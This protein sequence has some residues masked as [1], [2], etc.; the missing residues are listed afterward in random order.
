VGASN[1][2]LT[3]LFALGAILT[4]AGL[5]W[6]VIATRHDVAQFRS[7]VDQVAR[8]QESHDQEARRGRADGKGWRDNERDRNSRWKQD[9]ANVGMSGRLDVAGLLSRTRNVL[10]SDKKQTWMSLGTAGIGVTLSAVASVLA[11]PWTS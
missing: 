4:V 7:L 9:W 8:I 6:A 5:G 1:V 2:T 10:E 11:L 3:V